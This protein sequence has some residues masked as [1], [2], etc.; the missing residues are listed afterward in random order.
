MRNLRRH[1]LEVTINKILR[2]ICSVT[3][4]SF[5]TPASML[6]RMIQNASSTKKFQRVLNRFLKASGENSKDAIRRSWTTAHK[7]VNAKTLAIWVRP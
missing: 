3:W 2:I 5:L 4:I 1:V 7:L 6:A